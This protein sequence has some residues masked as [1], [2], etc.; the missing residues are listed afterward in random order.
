VDRLNV[1]IGDTVRSGDVVAR[2]DDDEHEQQVQQARAELGVAR[3]GLAE[4][5]SLVNVKRRQ[6][7]RMR[8]LHERRIASETELE[9]AQVEA[10]AQQARL[11]VA[12]AQVTQRQAALRAAEVRLAYTVI[13]ATWS[14]GGT[15]V[16]GERFANEGDLLPA[17]APILSIVE[18]DPLIAVVFAAER[19]YPSLHVGQLAVIT[20]EAF[21][22]QRFEGHIERLAPVFRESSRQ[23]RVEVRVTNPERVLKPGMFANVQV[24][25]ERAEGAQAVPVAALAQRGG[26]QGVF[27]VDAEARVARFVPV[28]KGIAQ[29]DR[30]QVLEPV[31]AGRVVTLGNHLLSDGTAILFSDGQSPGA[32]P[33][34]AAPPPP[35]RSAP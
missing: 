16:V 35:A 33:S 6:Y 19:D 10:E 31:L 8:T 12:Q 28:R 34:A 24:E 17:N 4:A 3:A 7:E 32:P 18:L 27:L 26:R 13:R 14:N 23:A 20:A 9:T 29:G 21:P 5:R 22:G 11:Q 30:V 2:L 1:D 15:R 25:L